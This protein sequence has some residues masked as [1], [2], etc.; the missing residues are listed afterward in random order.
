M[1]KQRQL[2]LFMLGVALCA[3]PIASFA[4]ETIDVSVLGDSGLISRTLNDIT[5]ADGCLK[6]YDLQLPEFEK[7]VINKSH[8]SGWCSGLPKHKGRF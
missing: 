7:G 3:I 6:T 2:P 1:F 8:I 5:P 4:N